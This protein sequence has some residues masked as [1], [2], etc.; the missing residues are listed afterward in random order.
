MDDVER[1]QQEAAR[2]RAVAFWRQHDEME[3]RLTRPVSERMLDLA[4]ISPGMRVLDV[5][6]GR[7]EPALP[8]AH[9][10]GPHGWV[11]AVDQSEGVLQIARERASREGLK[12]VEFQVADAEALQVGEKSFDV[13]TLRWGLMYMRAP[14]RALES[15]HR[16]LRP[17]GALVI[18]SWAEPARVPFASLARGMLE[19]YRDVPPLSFEGPGVFRHADPARLEAALQQA[20]FSVE[21]SEELDIPVVE[22]RDGRGIVA[23]IRELGGPVMKLVDELPQHQQQAW[24]EDISAEVEKTRAGDKVFLGGV[25][26]LTLARAL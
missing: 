21:A 20:G 25:T 15:I 2:A 4:R 26:R 7:G 14:E 6:A 16:A 17:G 11:L 23:W 19:R 3:A 10:V 1:Q 9:R 13:T 24:E 12:N 18:A 22:A 8:A 5:A